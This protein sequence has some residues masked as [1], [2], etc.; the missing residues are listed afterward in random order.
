MTKTGVKATPEEK[1]ELLKLLHEAQTT[2]VMLVGSV[3]LAGN[4]WERVQ[5]RC[6][7]IAKSHG[8]PEIQGYYGMDQD[9]EFVTE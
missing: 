8:L 3:D 4:A 9:G 2:P 1:E 7:E 6:H 5:T